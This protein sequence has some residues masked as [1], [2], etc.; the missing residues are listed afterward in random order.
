MLKTI[1]LSVIILGVAV[2]S[3]LA[4][5]Q[6][7]CCRV[8]TTVWIGT[9]DYVIDN[10]GKETDKIACA[11]DDDDSIVP[12]YKYVKLASNKCKNGFA[13]SPCKR[14]GDACTTTVNER[15]VADESKCKK[16]ISSKTL[17]SNQVQY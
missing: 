8:S 2:F 1:Y 11:S 6:E 16:A 14:I 12:Q 9:C 5:A 17:Q 13:D 15:T 4:S 7:V 3:S 10:E